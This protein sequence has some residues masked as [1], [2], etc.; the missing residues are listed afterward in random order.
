MDSARDAFL[1]EH[2]H[3]HD[4][5]QEDVKTAGIYSSEAAAKQAVERLKLQP[6][7]CDVPDGFTI[8]LYRLDLDCWTEGYIT[9]RGKASSE[10]D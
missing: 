1:V 6:G 7:F 10:Q 4:D 3:V 2:L 8:D 9:L 5:G